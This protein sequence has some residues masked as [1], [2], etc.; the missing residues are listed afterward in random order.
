MRSA[1]TRLGPYEVLSA[2]GAGGMGE[3]YKARDTRLDRIVAIKVLRDVLSVDPQ[4]RER[5][6]REA[7]TISQLDHPHICT[8]YDVGE[9]DGTSF[10]V[11]RLMHGRPQI[12]PGDKA[13]LF[14]VRRSTADAG[15]ASIEVVSLGDRHRKTVLRGG[16]AGRVLPS[17]HLVF[18]DRG[19]IFAIPFDLERLETHGR[20]VPV[21]DGVAYVAQSGVTDFDV[22]DGG[23]LVYRKGGRDAATPLSTLHWLDGTGRKTPLRD[24]PGDYEWPS[25]SPDGR[26]LALSVAVEGTRDVWIHD[27][28]RDT[29]TRLTIGANSGAPTWSPD[30]RYLV[31]SRGNA[32]GLS[33]TGAD[34]AGQ[35]QPLT[36]SR[37]FQVSPSFT[38]DGKRLVFVEPKGPTSQIWTVPVDDREGQLRVGTPELFLTV[39]LDAPFAIV[40][41]SPDGRW[42]AYPSTETG[43]AEVYV[44]PFPARPSGPGGKWQISNAGGVFP[45]WSRAGHE[46]FYQSGDQIM[47]VSYTVNG[48]AFMPEKPRVWAAKLGGLASDGRRRF[49]IEPDGKRLA[50]LTPVEP[51][52]ASKVDHEVVFVLN[53]LDE[54]RR[55]V[56]VGK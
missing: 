1:G 52:Q 21:L 44:R 19:T 56:P 4:F 18:G 12:L 23:T 2:L 43:S 26:R 32:G 30:G 45:T 7:R 54:L 37:N 53:F 48:D 36:Q 55:R 42:L 11:M 47:R 34:G 9:Q 27:W 29:M 39:P 5:F 20:A 22:S 28:Q 13:A 14:T 31:F 10:L 17:G 25:F 33:W 8:L 24:K 41:V 38:S 50:V 49:D 51:V 6:D 40:S 46:L 16:A 35:P 15:A 3:V